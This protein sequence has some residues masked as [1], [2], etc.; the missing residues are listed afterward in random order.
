MKV[1]YAFGEACICV[2]LVVMLGGVLFTA[3][4]FAL[5][6]R[7]I[8][9]IAVDRVYSWAVNSTRGAVFS[10]PVS[11]DRDHGGQHGR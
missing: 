6:A 2:L 10:V 3:V 9:G 11:V 1:V 8:L 4:N 7:E 5:I